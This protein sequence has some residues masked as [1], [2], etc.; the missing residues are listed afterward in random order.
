MSLNP[1][2]NKTLLHNRRRFRAA[3]FT[4]ISAVVAVAV[5][6]CGGGSGSAASAVTPTVASAATATPVKHV[7]VIF[8][9]NVSFDHY[10][11]TYPKA[12]NPP[13]Q[14]AF[15]G[16]G[17]TPAANT[18]LTPLDA[19]HGFVPLTGIDLLHDNPTAA[20][21]ANG[22]SAINPFRLD[23]T[24]AATADQNHEYDAEQK[25]FDAGRMDLFPATV[26]TP[27]TAATTALTPPLNTPGLV[28]G[29]YDGNTVTALWNYAQKYAMSDNSYGTT[30]GP[31]TVGAL[32]LIAGQ[33]NGVIATNVAA[34]SSGT[35]LDGEVSND[36]HGGMTVTGDPQPLGD[37]C[38]TRDAVR[39]TGIN[40]GDLLNAKGVSWG[41][42]EGGFDLTLTNANGTTGCKRSSTSPFTRQAKTDYIAHHQPFQYYA[43]TANLTH[44][45]PSSLAAIGHTYQADGTTL[46]PANHQYDLHDFYDAVSAG[47]YPAVSFLKAPGDQDGHAGYSSPLDEQAFIVNVVNFLQKQ[48]DWANT[49]VLI[50]YDDSDGWYDHQRSPIVNASTLTSA[51][52]AVTINGLNVAGLGDFLDGAG[53]CKT[54]LGN[55]AAP[56]QALAGPTGTA[57]VQARCGYGPRLPLLA[58]SPYAKTNFV[59]HTVT[60]QSSILRFIEDNWLGGQRIPGSFDGLANSITNMLDFTSGGTAPKVTLDPATGLPV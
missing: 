59:D 17:N 57:N 52:A 5:P 19:A 7:V 13:G 42:F 23:R 8:Q 40:I 46:D 3:A 1:T 27:D 60:D 26:G 16:A 32:N 53:V 20:N 29:Y 39:L 33:T 41:F 45:R 4:L 38:T 58:I 21:A 43:S 12:A 9:E 25:A 50:S 51:A 2:M 55:A 6:A 48:P 31:S 34:A 28:M 11:A 18:L 14:P 56:A 36:A 30:F 49:L 54:G 44:A 37:A 22:P 35:N 24:Q 15:T 47:N 10:F